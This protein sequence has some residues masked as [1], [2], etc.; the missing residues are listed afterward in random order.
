MEATSG[1]VPD[2]PEESQCS[3]PAFDC[4]TPP[5]S[6]IQ[7]KKKKKKNQVAVGLFSPLTP[8][9][10]QIAGLT[11]TPEKNLPGDRL[12]DVL[13]KTMNQV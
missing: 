6:P 13:N 7:K 8:E 12:V 2:S 9:A 5:D 10:S 1:K 11:Q 3:Q 4:N